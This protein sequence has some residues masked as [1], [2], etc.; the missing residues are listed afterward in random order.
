MAPISHVRERSSIDQ[1][2]DEIT[3]LDDTQAEDLLR[4]LNHTTTSNVPVNE[5]IGFFEDPDPVSRTRRRSTFLKSISNFDL[6]GGGV[7]GEDAP[8]LPEPRARSASAAPRKEQEQDA[9]AAA[10]ARYHDGGPFRSYKRISRPWHTPS[11]RD[12]L[13]A[14]LT[15]STPSPPPMSSASSAYSASDSPTT[16]RTTSS[17]LFFAPMIADDSDSDSPGLDLLEP[18]PARQK[19]PRFAAPANGFPAAGAVPMAPLTPMAAAGLAPCADGPMMSGIFE[20]L[21]AES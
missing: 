14:Y 2:F 20:V 4:D 21:S 15:G 10:A 13:M 19:Q 18:S 17:A 16:P 8:P 5:G 7:P 12:L 1:F 9:A 11:S 6:R 3:G